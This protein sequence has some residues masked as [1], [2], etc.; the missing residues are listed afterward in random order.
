[1]D[2]DYNAIIGADGKPV[3][4]ATA[5]GFASSL[6]VLTEVMSA[7]GPGRFV[8]DAGLKASSVPTYLLAT[9]CGGIDP[10]FISNH[11]RV[12]YLHIY[13]IFTYMFNYIFTYI[14]STRAHVIRIILFAST[15]R[16]SPSG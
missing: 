16:Y 11:A 15:C 5:D 1:M 2:G 12:I 4:E 7:P 13:L 3:G 14:L 9:M 10:T 6:F 8:V